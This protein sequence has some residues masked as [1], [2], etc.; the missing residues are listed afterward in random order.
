MRRGNARTTDDFKV[1]STLKTSVNSCFAVRPPP[2]WKE[3]QD[4]KERTE[5]YEQETQRH[6]EHVNRTWNQMKERWQNELTWYQDCARWVTAAPNVLRKIKIRFS[7]ELR[8]LGRQ[9]KTEAERLSIFLGDSNSTPEAQASPN[10]NVAIASALADH[11]VPAS[12]ADCPFLRGYRDVRIIESTRS[13]KS[14]SKDWNLLGLRGAQAVQVSSHRGPPTDRPPDKP[15]GVSV[16][17]GCS[18]E[19]PNTRQFHQ[20]ASFARSSHCSSGNVSSL[21]DNANWGSHA[22]EQYCVRAVGTSQRSQSGAELDASEV[23]S[24]H[25]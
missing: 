9:Q 13:E 1:G 24:V 5:K 18:E 16:F 22:I 20:L 3:I 23:W 10:L 4:L 21:A 19:R 11:A 17:A 7:Q 6:E 15:P 2:N 8:R 12:P 25:G 14:G